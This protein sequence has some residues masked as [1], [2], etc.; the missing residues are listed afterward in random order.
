MAAIF[1][2]CNNYFV[3]AG[4]DSTL[5]GFL[6]AISCE[7]DIEKVFYLCATSLKHSLSC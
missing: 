4:D 3:K 6:Q 1:P 5:Q 7:L 2:W